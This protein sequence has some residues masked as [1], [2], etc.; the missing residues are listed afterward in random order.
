VR[1]V[2]LQDKLSSVVQS[3]IDTSGEKRERRE[4]ERE[5]ERERGKKPAALGFAEKCE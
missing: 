4:R 3:S 2:I 1:F 5:R